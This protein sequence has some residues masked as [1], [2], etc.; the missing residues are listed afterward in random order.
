MQMKRFEDIRDGLEVAILKMEKSAKD[1]KSLAN[2]RDVIEDE[3]SFELHD[4]ATSL[5]LFVKNSWYVY[6]RVSPLLS[7]YWDDDET[8]EDVAHTKWAKK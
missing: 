8:T 4:I 3:L 1:L 6:T 5:E 2:V 7:K